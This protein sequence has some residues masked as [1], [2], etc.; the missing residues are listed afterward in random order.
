[1]RKLRI[2]TSNDSRLAFAPTS[3]VPRY[4][5]GEVNRC[6]ACNGKAWAV[7]RLYAE[8]TR[9]HVRKRDGRLVSG[10]VCGYAMAIV[11]QP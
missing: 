4:Y 3:F 8:C 9:E 1:M 11:R 5:E 10:E 7:G 6:P 2:V